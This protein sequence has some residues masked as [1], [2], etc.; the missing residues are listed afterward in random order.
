[1]AEFQ[2]F[3]QDDKPFLSVDQ[4]AVDLLEQISAADKAQAV[5][6]VRIW[7][8]DPKTGQPVRG[9]DGVPSSPLTIQSVTPPTF[10][11]LVG[12]DIRFRERPPVSLEQ[13]SVKVQ[14]PRG[15]ITYRTLDIAFTIHRPDVVFDQ[16]DRDVDSWSD[17][18]LPGN[19]FAMQYGWRSSQGV[20][21][22]IINGSGYSNPQASPPV[23]VP[24]ADTIRFTV[25]NYNFKIVQDGQFKMNVMAI[26]DGDFNLRQATLGKVSAKSQEDGN[27]IDIP[28]TPDPYSDEGK[29][30]I[31][32][33]QKQIGDDLRGKVTSD[34]L[35]SFKDLC[36]V[37]FADVVSAAYIDLGYKT[38]DMWLGRFNERVG[39]TS[40][41]YGGLDLSG[42]S[43]GDFMLP[44]RDVEKSFIDVHKIGGQLTL[45]N[46]IQIFLGLVQDPRVWDRSLAKIDKDGSQQH[47]LPQ[48]QTR[49]IVNGRD[50]AFYIFDVEREFTKFSPSDRFT[51]D[52]LFGGDYTREKIREVMKQKGVPL[53]S[54]RKGNSY[55]QDADFNVINDDQIKSIRI[56]QYL[57]PTRE[58][59][60]DVSK[61]TKVNTA[62]DP[63]Q[64][65]YSSA[66]M[67]ELTMLGNFVFD[68]FGLVW[69]D[70]GVSA[71]DGPFYIMSHE[72][73]I[74]PAGFYT[75]TTFHSAGTDPL[76]TQGRN[77]PPSATTAA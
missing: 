16:R 7:Q 9:K 24:A 27:R 50:A 22:G 37:L 29:A 47:T 69:L 76:G 59:V 39:R 31:A 44:L 1:M 10:G 6:F 62:V 28:V 70:F 54:F 35:V 5:P 36:D 61:K 75:R 20:K 60:N 12:D 63:R 74:S 67:G 30:L 18:I 26:Q 34:G 25:V 33:V 73:I 32:K 68:V 58:Q 19:I 52:E 71:W 65:L 55:I 4:G 13:I 3:E 21:N 15:I 45:H 14:S 8:I 66:I 11:A 56:R 77:P 64:V 41:K 48:L 46:F 53:I 49:T 38:P 23:L 57:D 17:L 43:L 51:K 2:E 40:E 72:D 42:H